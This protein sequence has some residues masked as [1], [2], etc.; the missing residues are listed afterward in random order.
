MRGRSEGAGRERLA[1]EAQRRGRRAPLRP[2]QVSERSMTNSCSSAAW[3]NE[4]SCL[5]VSV[6]PSQ[7]ITRSPTL[8]SLLRDAAES[9]VISRMICHGSEGKAGS[10]GSKRVCWL[11][12]HAGRARQ[13]GWLAAH[14]AHVQAE[15]DAARLRLASADLDGKHLRRLVRVRLAS[16]E[17]HARAG[18]RG[19]PAASAPQS[20]MA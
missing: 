9:S 14:V 12:P 3:M 16:E 6:A 2:V 1:R 20:T 8:S 4:L 13:E 10:I 7:P 18:A 5:P 19:G 11:R 17:G 15:P